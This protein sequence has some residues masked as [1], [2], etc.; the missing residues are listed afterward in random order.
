MIP[1]NIGKRSAEN[2]VV[3]RAFDAIEAQPDTCR[4]A[5]RRESTGTAPSV[6]RKTRRDRPIEAVD[7]PFRAIS[8]AASV[9]PPS[10]KMLIDAARA[11]RFQR[12]RQIELVASPASPTAMTSATLAQLAQA[13]RQRARREHDALRISG[14]CCEDPAARGNA[15]G[16]TGNDAHVGAHATMRRAHRQLRI[17]DAHRSGADHHGIVRDP[18]IAHVSVA[19]PR[20]SSR[21]RTPGRL[22]IAPSSDIAILSATYGRASSA[23]R[24]NTSTSS[25]ASGF[26]GDD[27]LHA[28]LAQLGGAAVLASDRACRRR[29][30]RC[31]PRA[32]RACTA[33]CGRR[34]GRAR[35][36]RRASRRARG[37][38]LAPSAIV[39]AC[40][41]PAR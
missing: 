20:S 29:R 14:F 8:C 17:V 26:V 28:V 11:Q 32:P 24:A 36:K 33:A 1:L 9:G 19:L 10:H 18:Q 4:R 7:L 12:G 6:R 13:R 16:L 39:S 30:A 15:F 41:S 21:S 2:H 3:A 35:A 5:L 25:R 22:A 37:R 31:P 38:R 40:A 27:D 34:A 23:L